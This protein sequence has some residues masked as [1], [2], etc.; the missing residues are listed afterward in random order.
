MQIRMS[1]ALLFTL[2]LAGSPVFAAS[3][4]TSATGPMSAMNYFIGSWNC[5]G[6]PVGQPAGKAVVAY[7]MELG[8]DIVQESLDV[9]AM[10]KNPGFRD[11]GSIAYDAKKHRFSSAGVDSMGGWGVSWSAGW[12]GDT[13]TWTDI[14]TADGD[15]GR[16]VATKAGATAYDLLGYSKVKGVEKVS[17]K[18]HCTKAPPKAK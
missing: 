18:V 2:A 16:I 15:L 7:E 14:A 6:G 12:K 9:A 1:F 17:L 4:P 8:G 5:T 3:E 11:L 13:I 10:G